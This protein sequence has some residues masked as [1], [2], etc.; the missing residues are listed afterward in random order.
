MPH[1]M[2]NNVHS[3]KKPM[4]VLQTTS[5]ATKLM[6]NYLAM[7]RTQFETYSVFHYADKQCQQLPKEGAKKL[8]LYI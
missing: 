5:D 7:F 6:W 2:T 4:I 1:Y 3:I 8:V